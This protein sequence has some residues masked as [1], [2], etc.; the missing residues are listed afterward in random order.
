MQRLAAALAGQYRVERELGEGGMAT[1]YLAHDLKHGRDVAIKTLHPELAAALGGERFLSEIKTTARLQ[2]PHI[3]PLLDSGVADGLLYY[4]MPYVAGETLR[5]RLERERQLPV[6][7]AVRIAREVAD[8][9][10][11]A[12]AMGII[13]RDI[14]PENILL[15]GGHAMVADFGIALAV[16]SAGGAR[17]TQTGLSLGTPQYMSPEQALG[18]RAIDARSDLYALGAVTYEMLAGDPPFTGSS[19]QAIVAKVLSER[20]TPLSMLRDTV[21]PAVESAVLRAL[22]KLPADRFASAAE[23]VAALGSASTGSAAHP[24]PSL[25][26]RSGLKAL[27]GPGLRWL[28]WGLL[29]VTIVLIV[30][31]WIGTAPSSVP[32][33]R[34]SIGLP[35]QAAWVE[36]DGSAMSL[37]SDGTLLAY[38]GRDSTAQQRL[39]IRAMDRLAPLPVNG[40]ENGALPIFSPDGRWL[41]FI[42]LGGL[43]RTPV[44]GGTPELVC[45]LG[46]Y[47]N[48]TW[49]ERDVVVFADGADLGLRQCALNGTVTTLLASDSGE[50][51]NFPHGLPGDRG[52][53][54]SVRRGT[55]ERLAVLDLRTMTR[56]SLEIVGTEPQYVETGHL[57]YATPDGVVRAIAFDLRTLTTTGGP[58]IIAEGV[59]IG[60]GGAYMAVSRGGTIVTAGRSE[61]E[62]NLVLVD[63]SGRGQRLHSRVGSFLD[64]R[65]SPDGRRIAVSLDGEIWLLDRA[66]GSLSRLTHDSLAGRPVWTPDGRDVAY[67]RQ[68]GARVEL[69][70]AA[71]DGSSPGRSLLSWPD[72]S[73]WQTTFAPDGKSM[74]VRTTGG[75]LAREMWHVPRD[76]ARRPV[77]LMPSP[78][79]EVAPALS[80]D[81][82]WLAYASNESGHYE[83][84]VRSFPA[85]G[86]RFAVSLDGGTE[87]V[88]SRNSNELFYRSGPKLIAAAVSTTGMFDVRRRTLLFS[89]G[90][91]E[92][93]PT[94]QGYDVASDGQHFVMVKRLGSAS[95]LTVTLHQFQ[96]LKAGLAADSPNE[97]PR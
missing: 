2:H 21:P 6:D 56:K 64:P 57:V 18:E 26:S 75:A 53:L 38:T 84:Y 62:R 12:H 16:Q 50:V 39:Y 55:A 89:D 32:V 8:A 51:F 93:D 83:I 9:L 31:G 44:G 11:S 92:G 24:A 30:N 49:L 73:L 95:L 19:V 47:V 29:A 22:A 46:G 85:M 80:P 76:S 3:L 88:W 70:A 35:E 65:F 90:D 17:M 33:Q 43:L 94:H 15:Q 79:D 96:H 77:A 86:A 40:G 54:F 14:K 66:Q 27:T 36:A 91:L 13:H 45:L 72:Y 97:R 52:V 61:S 68:T 37:S 4:V 81:G 59:R 25:R 60:S 48:T 82:R 10:G 71:A 20:P 42:G 69:R 28:P 5:A 41:A 74:V 34:F 67:V 87:P 58:F 78:A 7:D 23:F 63:R 1:V